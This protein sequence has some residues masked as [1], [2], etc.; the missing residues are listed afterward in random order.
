MAMPIIVVGFP[1]GVLAP[2]TII[3]MEAVRPLSFTL[4]LRLEHEWTMRIHR[5]QFKPKHIWFGVGPAQTKKYLVWEL[6]SSLGG[7]LSGHDH[8]SLRY[9][10]IAS[11]SAW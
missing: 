8:K 9:H 4:K 5:N 3:Q 10:R 2:R 1:R 7:A 11:T 6:V